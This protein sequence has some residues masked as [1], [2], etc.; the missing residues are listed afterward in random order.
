MV[1][2]I[3]RIGVRE[4][5][6]KATRYLSAEEVL[7]IERH[8]ALVGYFVPVQSPDE[9]S[10][11]TAAAERL[12]REAGTVDVL[13][14]LRSRRSE[15]I[16]LCARRGAINVRVFGSV[17]RGEASERSDVDLLVDFESGR[18]LLDQSALVGDL[19]DL[20][21]RKVDVVSKSS[22]KPAVRESV[23]VEAEEL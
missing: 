21:G 16:S 7:G 11:M 5:R 15:I 10:A 22:L 4:F 13:T 8:G 9:R 23:L 12:R 14:D 20:L 3:K 19:E 2:K 6:D 17:V 18:S 1:T